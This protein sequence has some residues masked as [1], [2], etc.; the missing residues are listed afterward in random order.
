MKGKEK[1]S[2]NGLL[3]YVRG[4]PFLTIAIAKAKYHYNGRW[5]DVYENINKRAYDDED[6]IKSFL[7]Q[8]Y[9]INELKSSERVALSKLS[10]IEYSGFVEAVFELLDISEYCVKCLCNTY[11]L[12]QQDSILYYMD[13]FHRKIIVKVLTDD[14]NLKSAIISIN[15]SLSKWKIHKDNGFKWTS[16]YIEKI[17]ENVQGYAVH[18]MDEELFYKFSY[19]VAIKYENIKDKEKRL[20]WIEFCKTQDIKFVYKKTYIELRAKAAFIDTLFSFSEVNQSYLEF[21]K[22]LKQIMTIKIKDIS[23][24]SIVIS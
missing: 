8:L 23:C 22:K 1:A 18:I 24:K 14:F 6:Y 12:K 2:V 15:D 4:N 16:P 21:I 9:R 17:L 20:K 5:T 13:E 3:S 7:R 11:W 19:Q 10:T